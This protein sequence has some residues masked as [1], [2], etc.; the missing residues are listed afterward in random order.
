MENRSL[1]GE[2][3][4]K[5]VT[6]RLEKCTTPIIHPLSKNKFPLPSRSSV[7]VNS[8]EKAQIAKMKSDC[9]PFSRLYISC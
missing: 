5:L 3:Y 9:G 1:G 6:E 8:Y 2:K 4:K 7:K